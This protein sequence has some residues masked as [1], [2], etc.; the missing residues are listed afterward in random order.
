MRSRILGLALMLVAAV[1]VAN[2][3]S[4]AA[5]DQPTPTVEDLPDDFVPAACVGNCDTA[6][7][8]LLKD[9]A[10]EY[11]LQESRYFYG[12][13]SI[14]SGATL[15]F[16]GE[17]VRFWG[18]NA[19]DMDDWPD[20]PWARYLL[21]M[22]TAVGSLECV[23]VGREPNGQYV[24]ACANEKGFL[25]IIGVGVGFLTMD[26]DDT[27]FTGPII[28]KLSFVYTFAKLREAENAALLAMTGLARGEKPQPAEICDDK[29]AFSA[30]RNINFLKRELADLGFET[31]R[32]FAGTARAVDG[33]TLVVSG[34]VVRL[35]GISAPRADL[36]PWGPRARQALQN[37]IGTGQIRCLQ[38]SV[39]SDGIPVAVC[40]NDEHF[41]PCEALR[42]GSVVMRREHVEADIEFGY[43]VLKFA[44]FGVNEKQ[45]EWG[46][47]GIWLQWQLNSP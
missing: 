17:I 31:R 30:D 8:T 44:A 2:V 26:P 25:P 29:S 11:G 3:P 1:V 20:G 35:W 21:E 32:S 38:F 39:D 37:D 16:G 22:E 12:D 13:F 10:R 9:A 33:K 42:Q 41:V 15:S 36:I 18:L 47:R 45:A 27:R 19:P 28:D 40:A 24:V 46:N 14:V 5:S 34:E 4:A 7:V 6:E 43:T 23:E